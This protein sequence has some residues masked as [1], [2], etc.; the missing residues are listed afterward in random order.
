MYVRSDENLGILIGQK[1]V[2]WVSTNQK[3]GLI[4]KMS[5]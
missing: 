1:L 4:L 3:N 5:T 2:V